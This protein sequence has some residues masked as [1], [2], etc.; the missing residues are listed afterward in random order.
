[1][2]TDSASSPCEKGGKNRRHACFRRF[3]IEIS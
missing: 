3:F 1:V 2:A